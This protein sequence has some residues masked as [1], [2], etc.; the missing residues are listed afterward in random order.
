MKCVLNWQKLAV[1]KFKL[2]WINQMRSVDN[3]MDKRMDIYVDN[4]MDNLNKV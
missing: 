2:L 4:Y 3:F 1:Q